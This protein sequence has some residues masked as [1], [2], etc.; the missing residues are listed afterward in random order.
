[1]YLKKLWIEFAKCFESVLWR[2]LLVFE[3]A[4][5]RFLQIYFCL[6]F[7]LPVPLGFWL[8]VSQSSLVYTSYLLCFLYFPSYL[9]AGIQTIYF[10]LLRLLVPRSRAFLSSFLL[11]PC[12]VLLILVI[13]YFSSRISTWFLLIDS[14]KSS[15]EILY[16]SSILL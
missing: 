15:A 16:L 6:S 12:T 5:L 8:W 9:L 7:S 13:I 10:L 3:T 11:N 1:M 2:T 4:L 14:S